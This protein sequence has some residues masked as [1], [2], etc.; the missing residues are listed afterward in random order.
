MRYK[1]VCD[2]VLSEGVRGLAEKMKALREGAMLVYWE[3]AIQVEG[4]ASAKALW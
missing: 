2:T 1:D 3:R 4:T